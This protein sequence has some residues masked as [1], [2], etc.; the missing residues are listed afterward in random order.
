MSYHIYCLNGNTKI[1]E[2]IT[3]SFRTANI[4]NQV[5]FNQGYQYEEISNWYGINDRDQLHNLVCTLGHAKSIELFLR[6]PFEYGI[7]CEDDI[8][9]HR[10]I[11]TIIPQGV[12]MM[13]RHRL[14]VLLMGYLLRDRSVLKAKLSDQCYRFAGNN[15]SGVQM[16]MLTRARASWLF[17]NLYRYPIIHA[18]AYYTNT[19]TRAA[20]YSIVGFHFEVLMITSFILNVD[21]IIS[22]MIMY[23]K[24]KSNICHYKCS[25]NGDVMMVLN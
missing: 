25:V 12:E 9:I 20:L 16:F 14:D 2:R 7:L 5:T 4:I 18:D 8:V 21:P 19:G 10:D 6:S 22:L 24:L 11:K 15:I 1:T 17:H 3:T 23:K 13:K